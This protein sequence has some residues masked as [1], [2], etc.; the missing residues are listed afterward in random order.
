MKDAE[1]TKKELCKTNTQKGLQK[2]R[3]ILQTMYNWYGPKDYFNGPFEVIVP[4]KVLENP[5]G[6]FDELLKKS[7]GFGGTVRDLAEALVV[8]EEVMSERR[9]LSAGKKKGL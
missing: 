7:V 1:L 4:T 6:V 8:L 2:A 5:C 3:A 9:I